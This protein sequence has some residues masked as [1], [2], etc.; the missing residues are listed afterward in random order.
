MKAKRLVSGI[1]L[2]VL[3]AGVICGASASYSLIEHYEGTKHALRDQIDKDVVKLESD[4]NTFNQTLGRHANNQIYANI[5]AS[6]AMSNETVRN[7]IRAVL[8]FQRA[9]I[10]LLSQ[11]QQLECMSENCLDECDAMD[12][13]G[14]SIADARSELTMASD[15]WADM[16]T[17]KANMTNEDNVSVSKSVLKREIAKRGEIVLKLADYRDHVLK[18]SSILKNELEQHSGE[19]KNAKR[20]YGENKPTLDSK[21]A[22]AKTLLDQSKDMDSHNYTV[23]KSVYDEIVQE[24]NDVEDLARDELYFKAREKQKGLIKAVDDLDKKI[25]ADISS[26]KGEEAHRNGVIMF[27]IALICALIPLTLK[28]K[29]LLEVDRGL[30]RQV[31][32]E[33]IKMIVIAAIALAVI[34]VLIN[35]L[36]A[37]L[38]SLPLFFAIT[39]QSSERRAKL[40]N[41]IS[42]TRFGISSSSGKVV[43]VDTSPIIAKKI[44]PFDNIMIPGDMIT[45]TEVTK[46]EPVKITEN[47]RNTFVRIK[48][49]IKGYVITIT[50]SD[51]KVPYQVTSEMFE[52]A[53][54]N[55]RNCKT[56]EEKARALFDWLE[57][58]LQ[59][60]TSKRGAV[61]YRNSRE[62][63][64]QKEGVCGEMAYTLITLFRS[65]GLRA[66][67][68]S[69]AVDAYG[70]RVNHGCV[71]VSIDRHEV[72]VDIAYHTFDIHHLRY[73][74]IS[75]VKAIKKFQAWR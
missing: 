46:E 68:V 13:T 74:K 71:W 24:K 51:V 43:T 32:A 19:Y 33:L 59:Y 37:P 14:K 28:T 35:V 39:Y 31:L 15:I 75:D 65:V 40:N 62:V 58:E 48:E 18:A 17:C 30:R 54:E 6:E 64:E 47:I 23:F 16:E 57:A 42:S 67:Y 3:L 45:P 61:G 52:R 11:Y 49:R 27:L 4:F 7:V 53:E 20:D 41:V 55:T 1:M 2:V 63:Y 29:E 50:E 56:A 5:Y 9:D 36:V 60:G 73:S 70:N 38:L 22:K 34:Y 10:I 66:G 21:L 72:L 12:I 25:S 26:I 44:N 69:V 8:K